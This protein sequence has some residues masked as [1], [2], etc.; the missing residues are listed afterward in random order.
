MSSELP[1][2]VSRNVLLEI[3]AGLYNP[4]HAFIFPATRACKS[5]PLTFDIIIW[6]TAL[7]VV[8]VRRPCSSSMFVITLSG[9]SF[10]LLREPQLGR[11]AIQIDGGS[12]RPHVL[13]HV[14]FRAYD[15]GDLG[16]VP[17]LWSGL[18]A[19][20][21]DINF[22]GI[23]MVKSTSD[24]TI[25]VLIIHVNFR[26]NLSRGGNG[27]NGVQYYPVLS[28]RYPGPYHMTSSHL[29][30][31]QSIYLDGTR[32]SVKI[33]VL[34]R[35]E[36]CRA[37]RR[38]ML[39]ILHTQL[40]YITQH[41]SKMQLS[42]R[43]DKNGVTHIN[44]TAHRET[45]LLTET[46]DSMDSTTLDR[47]RYGAYKRVARPTYS[48]P[49]AFHAVAGHR[50]QQHF[51]AEHYNRSKHIHLIGLYNG[52][53]MGLFKTVFEVNNM[54][55]F[56]KDKESS[57][58]SPLFLVIRDHLGTTPLANLRNTLVQDLSKI[59]SSISKTK[60]GNLHGH[61]DKKVIDKILLPVGDDQK[62]NFM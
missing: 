30:F 18:S 57:L 15:D 4:S 61:M 3:L 17:V 38:I 56:L 13:V 49:H 22:V 41:T 14:V 54:Q 7:V 16:K 58:R 9:P 52:A 10:F 20:T 23:G 53:N 27:Q 1:V 40:K 59:W 50:Q 29:R 62:P 34:T 26:Q 12:T 42:V 28:A 51:P 21:F 48:D 33:R 11:D 35:S 60:T 24:Y 31:T 47:R 25:A 2:M 46:S 36:F 55:L 39:S 32:T 44:Q 19:F 8:H 6:T 37:M 5:K 43:A 45:L